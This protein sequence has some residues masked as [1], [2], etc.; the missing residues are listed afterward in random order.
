MWNG[1]SLLFWFIFSWWLMMNI[2][3]SAFW[4]FLS[5]LW[6]KVYLDTLP[7]LI[8]LFGFLL[9][10]ELFIC[11]RCKSLTRYMTCR[12]L[13]LWTVFTLFVHVYCTKVFNSDEEAQCIY[14]TFLSL[15]LLVSFLRSFFFSLIWGHE[16]LF[17]PQKFLLWLSGNES[18]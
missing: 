11:S 16:D 2:F 4:P 18:D 5:L 13:I 9:L 1:I 10:W 17:T 7:V 14:F 8:G 15:V 12:C 6:R 3:S